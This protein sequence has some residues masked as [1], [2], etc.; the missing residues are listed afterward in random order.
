MSRQHL[1]EGPTDLLSFE[2]PVVVAGKMVFHGLASVSSSAPVWDL[3]AGYRDWQ[4]QRTPGN[5]DRMGL[6]RNFDNCYP[7]E[8]RKGS[9]ELKNNCLW[10][11]VPPGCMTDSR[12]G[13]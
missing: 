1:T 11:V 6:Q 12:I 4:P 2:S 8:K 13:M 7:R 9:W 10:Q 3:E 5:E